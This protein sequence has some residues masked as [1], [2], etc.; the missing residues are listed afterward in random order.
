MGQQRGVAE[1]PLATEQDLPYILNRLRDAK[2]IVYDAETSGLDFKRS[3]IVGHVVSFT[4]NSA[5][6]WYLPVRHFGSNNLFQNTGPSEKTG[7]D[8]K[9][10]SWEDDLIK[11]LNRQNLTIIGQNLAFDLKFLATIGHKLSAKYQDTI[12]NAPL[13][14]EWSGKFN[15]E[16]LANQAGLTPKK[17]ALI[18]AHILQMFPDVPENDPKNKPMAHFWRLAGNDPVAVEYACGDGVTTFELRDWQMPRLEAEGLLKVWA[19]ENRLIPI[20]ARMSVK[21][22]RIDTDYLDK[23]QIY[24]ENKIDKLSDALPLDFNVRSPVDMEKYCRDHNAT[25]WPLTPK[26][27]P[28]FPETWLE[29]FEAGQTI[30]QS[31]KLMTLLSM[32]ILPLKETHIFNGRVHTNLHQLRGDGLGIVTGRIGSSEPSLQQIPKRD[33]WLGPLFRACFIPDDGMIFADPDYS[34]LEPRLLAFYSRSKVLLDDYR[35]NPAADAHQ[36]V[37]DAAGIERTWGKNANMTI[38]NGG[39]RGILISKYR[40]PEHKVDELLANYWRSMPEVKSLQKS[41]EKVMRYRGYVRS[42]LDRR[43]RLL[44]RDKAYMALNRLLQ[45]GN[46]DILKL[47]M[48]EIDDY[49]ASENRPIDVLVPVHD[50][51]LMQF[52]P[53]AEKHYQECLAIMARCGPDDVI[54]LDVPLKVNSEQG[55]NWSIATYG[56]EVRSRV[57][58]VKAITP[59]ARIKQSI[60][61]DLVA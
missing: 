32:F 28:S 52:S 46:A 51:L 41:S 10:E 44:S 59:V 38:I 50:A 54:K 20:L 23:I 37:A 48:C 27:R 12:I 40:V 5:D 29:T 47:K 43:S 17:S 4:C 45:C 55:E 61:D 1:M 53:D 2:E 39:G 49:L 42:L 7:W 31:R 19:I 34:Q 26:G 58:E 18:D 3:H 30:I 35:N 9:T 15:L 22:V 56:N 16:Y 13:L 11:L 21:G 24:T 6:S 36:A 8:G 33:K 60:W 14:N 57:D 25:N